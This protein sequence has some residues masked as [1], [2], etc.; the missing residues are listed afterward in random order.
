MK[1]EKSFDPTE[2]ESWFNLIRLVQ[3]VFLKES[4]FILIFNIIA[5]IVN[6]PP[7]E[8][9]FYDKILDFFTKTRKIAK[10]C[11]EKYGFNLFEI[12]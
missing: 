9:K 2:K 6:F 11:M 4:T 1:I 10:H 7:M 5:K 12:N 8:K 3:N